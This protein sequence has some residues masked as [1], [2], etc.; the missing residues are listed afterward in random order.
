MLTL[1]KGSYFT[2]S[3]CETYAFDYIRGEKLLLLGLGFPRT[4]AV[5]TIS[6]GLRSE[7]ARESRSLPVQA[8]R[9]NTLLPSAWTTVLLC[10]SPEPSSVLVSHWLK[11]P[12]RTAQ[13]VGS[14]WWFIYLHACMLILH[15]RIHVHSPSLLHLLAWL[16]KWA[17]S[18]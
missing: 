1:Q 16:A 13:A 5:V 11:I 2:E 9:Q 4:P 14:W 12:H 17:T 3:G 7:H 6:G 15:A 8:S 10:I 18:R